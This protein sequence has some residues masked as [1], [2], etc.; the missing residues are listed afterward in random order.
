MPLHGVGLSVGST[1]AL[2]SHGRHLGGRPGTGFGGGLIGVPMVFRFFLS[3]IARSRDEGCGRTFRQ[4]TTRS[5][6]P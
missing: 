1:E 3:G 4:I 6:S 2:Q 5:L